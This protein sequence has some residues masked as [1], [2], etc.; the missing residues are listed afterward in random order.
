MIKSGVDMGDTPKNKSHPYPTEDD[1]CDDVWDVIGEP[2]RT[3]PKSR[4]ASIYEK[5]SKKKFKYTKD[6]GMFWVTF[7]LL[8]VGVFYTVY[9]RNMVIDNRNASIEQS[10]LT[11]ES[12]D[13][14]RA[15]LF[16]SQRPWLKIENINI[17]NYFL[18]NPIS[19]NVEARGN[20][21][22]IGAT[23]AQNISFHIFIE[24][25][26]AAIYPGA[27]NLPAFL[28]EKCS[29]LKFNMPALGKFG[30]FAFPKD[31]VHA[32]ETVTMSQQHF[33]RVLRQENVKSIPSALVIG[34]FVY[35][36][37]F[38]SSPHCTAI[39]YLLGRRDGKPIFPVPNERVIIAGIPMVGIS[40]KKLQFE[41]I[42]LGGSYAD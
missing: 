18:A 9:T 35:N 32:I 39:A 4:N 37:T 14:N 19:I 29:E 11:R 30:T 10:F 3:P 31:D 41:R 7:A 34:A 22:N 8:V 17:T 33:E 13:I 15:M 1:P 23:P 27:N 6:K 5:Y 24:P 40:S 28:G 42:G 36:S 12:N 26:A 25:Y 38:E 21:N 20:D 16:A 2:S